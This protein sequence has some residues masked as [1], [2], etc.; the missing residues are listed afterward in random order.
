MLGVGL[1]TSLQPR[2]TSLGSASRRPS[3]FLTSPS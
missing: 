1:G 3:R 2:P